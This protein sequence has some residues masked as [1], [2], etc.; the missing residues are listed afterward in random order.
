MADPVKVKKVEVADPGVG[1]V[2]DLSDPSIPNPLPNLTVNV[3]VTSSS[4]TYSS[5]VI[6]ST[7]TNQREIILVVPFGDTQYSSQV[8]SQLTVTIS[9]SY[10]NSSQ[11]TVSLGSTSEQLSAQAGEF[12]FG[13]SRSYLTD[14]V[15]FI[16]TSQSPW[17]PGILLPNQQLKSANGRYA[18][19]FRPDGSLGVFDLTGFSGN[20]PIGT[21]ALQVSGNPGGGKYFAAMQSNGNFGIYTLVN[22]DPASPSRQQVYNFANSTAPSFAKLD[23]DGSLKIYQGKPGSQGALIT[24]LIPAP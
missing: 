21:L 8:G 5:Q 15:N 1:F 11:Q 19:R 9:V 12:D 23:G 16:A 14:N 24:T 3:A 13:V 6:L 7:P 10:V 17:L 4:S 18:C 2:L 22:D 20:N